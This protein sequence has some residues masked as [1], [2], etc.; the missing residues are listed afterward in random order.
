Q[1]H[2]AETG[3]P[4]LGIPGARPAV[5]AGTSE[6]GLPR[7]GRHPPSAPPLGPPLQSMRMVPRDAANRRGF[8]RIDHLL[9][10]IRRVP[11]FHPP[12]ETSSACDRP[13]TALLDSGLR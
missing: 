7:R 2:R 11:A 9:A 1:S 6:L 12:P 8:G 13:L 5:R 10:G 3:T 4:R